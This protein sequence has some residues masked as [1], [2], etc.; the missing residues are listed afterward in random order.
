MTMGELALRV[1]FVDDHVDTLWALARLFRRLGC[2]TLTAESCAAARAVVAAHGPVDVAVGD[3]GLPD[4][5]G[6][7]LLEELKRTYG[8]ATAVALTAHVMPADA[9]RYEAS[10]L[11]GWL[12]K[13]AGID[14]LRRVVEG[15]GARVNRD[16]HPPVTRKAG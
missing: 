7:A 1:L 8:A 3:V 11:D 5:D 13:P 15:L 16:R 4:G 12:A 14:E 9:R 6:V 2:E 10:R